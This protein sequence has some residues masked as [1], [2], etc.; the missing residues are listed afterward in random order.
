MYQDAKKKT[1]P[2]VSGRLA[3]DPRLAG[4]V[5]YW[6]INSKGKVLFQVK[7]FPGE[8]LE[9]M[10]NFERTCGKPVPYLVGA[11]LK[12]DILAKKKPV[13]IIGVAFLPG[14]FYS[15]F[16][17]SGNLFCGKRLLLKS[18]IGPKAECFNEVFTKKTL[19]A[20]VKCLDSIFLNL[21]KTKEPVPPMIVRALKD[22]YTSRG[23]S[24]VSSLAQTSGLTRFI[25]NSVFKKWIGVCP[26]LLCKH[27]RFRLAMKELNIGKNT[28]DV[29]AQF[30]YV[31]QAHFIRQFKRRVGKTPAAYFKRQSQYVKF[32]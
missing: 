26:R 27:I 20:R 12:S 21:A 2:F 29:S 10:F 31:D 4:L 5:R 24:R 23:K 17:V 32:L 11:Q 19:K 7:R 15:L 18:A 13:D 1:E 16:H 6:S 14:A 28:A 3:P 25:F 30:G 22:I 9:L 8:Q